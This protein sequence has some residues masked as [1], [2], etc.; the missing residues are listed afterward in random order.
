MAKREVEVQQLVMIGGSAGSIEV[1]FRLI[2][3]LSNTLPFPVVIVLHRKIS[4]DSILTSLLASKTR[5]KVKEIEEKDHLKAGTIYIAPGDYHLL[6]EKDHTL[7]LD[8]S[9]KINF[10]RPS[11]DV[12]YQSAADVYGAN[13][14][15]ILLSGANADG[16][17]G[18]RYVKSKGGTTIAQLPETAEVAFMPEQAI[19]KNVVD[20][21]LGIDAIAAYVN[22]LALVS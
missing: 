19:L 1:L 20:H 13:L 3:G 17:D 14:T 8:Y 22:D 18:F 12:A 16:T 4:N 9:E 2:P 10:S 21:V 6:F 11:I 5:L 7:S 15:C